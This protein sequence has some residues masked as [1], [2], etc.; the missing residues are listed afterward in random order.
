M[1]LLDSNVLIYAIQPQHS[2]LR[3][4]INQNDVAISDISKVEVLGYHK[5]SEADK[6]DFALLFDLMRSLPLSTPI[7]QTA[8][9]LRQQRKMSL[10]DAL[11]A[12]T[13]LTA[14]FTLATRNMT[15]FAWIP[16]LAL[17]NPVD[18]PSAT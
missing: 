11:I 18:T 12:A 1:Y 10:G 17:F 3:A 5:L 8:V 4:W 7:V 6:Q 14:G 13:A 2:A 15:D 16:G 9:Q